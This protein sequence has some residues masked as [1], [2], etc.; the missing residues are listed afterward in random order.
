MIMITMQYILI[1]TII[2]LNVITLIA[3]DIDNC[4][5]LGFNST[6]LECKSCKSLERIIGISETGNAELVKECKSCCTNKIVVDE[7]YEYAVLE[8]I[9]Y[10]Y[11]Y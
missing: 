2:L 5:E 8:V 4:V 10:F 1:I 7:Q 6:D 3:V 11:Y 9:S